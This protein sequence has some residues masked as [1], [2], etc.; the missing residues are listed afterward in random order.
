M[1]LCLFGTAIAKE[2]G[3]A[4]RLGL[5]RTHNADHDTILVVATIQNISSHP[6]ST[7]GLVDY[8]GGYKPSA[9]TYI[10]WRALCDSL[11][12]AASGPHYRDICPMLPRF[13][14]IPRSW[15]TPL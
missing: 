4:F 5:S 2:G 7:W 8:S 10:R 13:G 11:L 12:A 6:L 1:T 9:E 15:R 14:L 3:L